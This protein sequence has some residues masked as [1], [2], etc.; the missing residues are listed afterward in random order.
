MAHFWISKIWSGER[1]GGL[2]RDR[3]ADPKQ[4]G[5]WLASDGR[6]REGIFPLGL[7][8]NE[9]LSALSLRAVR[10][11]RWL[12]KSSYLSHHSCPPAMLHFRRKRLQPHIC[13]KHRD[14]RRRRARFDVCRLDRAR[15]AISLEKLLDISL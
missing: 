15:N 13:G 14:N 9:N 12:T 7:A 11:L 8:P 4:S 5:R 3:S 10:G 2:K 6:G 1:E